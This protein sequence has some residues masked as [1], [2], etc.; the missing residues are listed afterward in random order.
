MKQTELDKTLRIVGKYYVEAVKNQLE[1]DETTAT[2]SLKDSI[3]YKLIDGSIDIFMAEHGKAIETGTGPASQGSNKVSKRFI[4]DIIQWMD[5]KPNIRANT[6]VE[7]SKIANAIARGIKR[8]GIIKRFGNTGTKMMDIVYNRLE[9]Q[10]GDDLSAAYMRDL[11]KELNNL[12]TTS[13][14]TK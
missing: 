6:P 14:K 5:T 1:K 12:K 4:D 7:K 8:G 2:G 9:K 13:K 10:I 3:G 11:E